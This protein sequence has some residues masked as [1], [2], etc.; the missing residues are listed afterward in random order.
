[1]TTA[2]A[3]ART[4]AESIGRLAHAEPER[5]LRTQDGEVVG[6]VWSHPPTHTRVQGLDH[7]ALALHLSGCTLVEKWADGRMRGHRSRVGSVSLVPAGRASEWLIGGHCRV[8]HAYVHPLAL[9]ETA[10]RLERRW[11]QEGLEDFFALED[12]QLA[13]L[14]QWLV[15]EAWH[16]RLDAFGQ[17]QWQALLLSHLVRLGA[18]ADA[19]PNGHDARRTALTGATLRRLFAHVEDHLAERLTLRA[20]AAIAHLSPDH[21]LRAF[22]QAVGQTPHQYVLNRR[23]LRAQELLTRSKQPVA[24]VA[25]EAGFRGASH[26]SAA[27]RREYGVTP[28]AWRV[29]QRR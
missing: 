3:S 10:E 2:H 25:R 15:H 6:A 19:M 21:F 14:L 17:E 11:P 26:F 20:M 4:T 16:D 1:M 12:A 7:H 27:F 18:G 13:R 22:K 9:A 5:V 8:A 28:S 23:L 29:Q 24:E